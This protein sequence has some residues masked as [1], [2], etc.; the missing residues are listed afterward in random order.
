MWAADKQA[1]TDSEVLFLIVPSRE[2]QSLQSG[3][4][5]LRGMLID[6]TVSSIPRSLY[7]N[8]YL[9][10]TIYCSNHSENFQKFRN[11]IQSNSFITGPTILSLALFRKFFKNIGQCCNLQGPYTKTIESTAAPPLTFWQT[12]YTVRGRIQYDL[13][14]YS[15]IGKTIFG[16]CWGSWLSVT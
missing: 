15:N 4:F 16:G 7:Q 11:F 8:K 10:V 13:P 5:K 12:N 3:P 9:N 1:K 2:T 14:K 6:S